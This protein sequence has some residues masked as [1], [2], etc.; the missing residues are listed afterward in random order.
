MSANGFKAVVDI[1][2]LGTF[3]TCRAVFEH[4]KR[5]GASIINISALQAFTPIPMQA[6]VCAAKA[7][8]D[9][10]TKCLAIEW[11]PEGVRINSIAPGSVDD[12]EGMKRLAPTPEIKKQ[13]TRGIPLG[14][15]ATKDE[16]ADLALFLCSDA[17]K[18]ITGAV[19]VCDGGQS[20]AGVGL[21]RMAAKK[22]GHGRR[23]ARGRFC[24]ARSR[25]RARL[26]SDR[27]APPTACWLA[28][29][30]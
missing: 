3:N 27:A 4:L 18:F 14:R 5:P 11:G 13:V 9:M 25:A 8:V 15:F 10:L 22:H 17:A 7:G 12:T 24:A 1:D 21:S 28:D 23:Y 29:V 19:V 6:H 26:S 2:L 20:I 16:I 30:T